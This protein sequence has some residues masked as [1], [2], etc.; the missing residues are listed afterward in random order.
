MEFKSFEEQ[1]KE[2]LIKT[3]EKYIEE[4]NV[5][6]LL[7]CEQNTDKSFSQINEDFNKRKEK[8]LIELE[9]INNEIDS[10]CKG[11]YKW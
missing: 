6:F 11:F 9:R 10:L 7:Y 3:V 8:Y 2:E 5:W 4:K 1:S